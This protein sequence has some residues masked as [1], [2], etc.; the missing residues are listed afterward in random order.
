MEFVFGM[1]LG[2]LIGFG[3]C[4][5]DMLFRLDKYNAEMAEAERRLAEKSAHDN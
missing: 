2:G 3:V 5:L 1:V 4:A